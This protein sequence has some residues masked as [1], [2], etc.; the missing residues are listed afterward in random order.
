MVPADCGRA[1]FR[2]GTL[3]E[4]TG[5]TRVAV[6]SSATMTA[7]QL[8]GRG[9][10]AESAT[11]VDGWGTSHARCGLG[12]VAQC[13]VR[14]HGDDPRKERASKWLMLPH[15]LALEAAYV[16]HPLR[17]NALARAKRA[18]SR[19]VDCCVRCKPAL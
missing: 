2:R 3:S 15:S 10:S 16:E 9:D 18:Q 8:N 6:Y 12:A 1:G 5:R 17:P 19:S 4:R 13:L 11:H 14:P 7:Q